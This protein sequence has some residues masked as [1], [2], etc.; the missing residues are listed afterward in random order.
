[1]LMCLLNHSSQCMWKEDFHRKRA[2]PQVL[3]ISVILGNSAMEI[4]VGQEYPCQIGTRAASNWLLCVTASTAEQMIEQIDLHVEGTA[5]LLF[6]SDKHFLRCAVQDASLYIPF[7]LENQEN[8][9]SY[10]LCYLES[11]SNV[12]NDQNERCSSHTDSSWAFIEICSRRSMTEYFI[13]VL[14]GFLVK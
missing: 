11:I 12:T 2:V 6:S 9:F 4:Q 3:S 1:M 13:R 14:L 10:C 5:S 7:M 8:Y